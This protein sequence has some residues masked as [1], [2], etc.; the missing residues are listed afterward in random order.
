MRKLIIILFA[1][2]YLFGCH[3]DQERGI[4][5]TSKNTV[6]DTVFKNLHT[7]WAAEQANKTEFVDWLDENG[8]YILAFD[9]IQDSISN[10]PSNEIALKGSDIAFEHGYLEQSLTFLKHYKPKTERDS[11][12]MLFKEY[13]LYL[14]QLH[15]WKENSL[16]TEIEKHLSYIK[17]D[18]QL[19]FQ[20]SSDMGM[21]YHNT[22]RYDTAIKLNTQAYNWAKSSNY[23]HSIIAMCCQRLGN[24]YND[25][26][27]KKLVQG[28]DKF[29]AYKKAA[30]L[31][32][33]CLNELNKITP[34]PKERIANCYFTYAFLVRAGNYKKNDVSLYEKALKMIVPNTLQRDK[35]DPIFCL[36]PL[37]ASIIY[38]HLGECL[39]SDYKNTHRSAYTAKCLKYANECCYYFN[40]L[41]TEPDYQGVFNDILCTYSQR[42]TE[43][44]INYIY[45]CTPTLKVDK[46]KLLTLSNSCKYALLN[47]QHAMA[48]S[49][50]LSLQLSQI[51]MLH[52]LEYMAYSTGNK[53][54]KNIAD[55]A[56]RNI[57]T[58]KVGLLYLPPAVDSN[59]I[60]KIQRICKDQNLAVIDFCES[61]YKLL[62][63]CIDED[64]VI[65]RY[66]P[67][68]NSIFE[69]A[70]QIKQASIANDPRLYD[71]LSNCLYRFLFSNFLDGKKYKKIIIVPSTVARAALLDGLTSSRSDSKQWSDLDYLGNHFV[72]QVVPRIDWIINDKG[73]SPSRFNLFYYPVAFKNTNSLPY[74]KELERF[75]AEEYKASEIKTDL[76][77]QPKVSINGILHIATHTN[78]DSIGSINLLLDKYSINPMK[79]KPIKCKMVVLN[80]CDASNGVRYTNEG[81]ISLARLFIAQGADAVIT[82]NDKVDNHASAE[83]FKRFY[84]YLSNGK[85]TSESLR[86]SKV[87][88]RKI[89][90]EWANPIYWT[91][92]QLWGKD[93]TFYR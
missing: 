34:L 64:R 35:N 21:H 32:E 59:Y 23:D 44:L 77:D 10:H 58:D 12:V 72:I 43:Q 87:D 29:S 28:K 49:P 46:C 37:L 80:T 7:I 81:Q 20:Y 16:I 33:E 82:S 18:S 73:E 68:I 41:L 84:Y 67:I 86:L 55:Y 19:Y 75:L 78:I 45:D 52:S 50:S 47:K 22:G 74:N 89:T 14:S 63:T 3:S 60:K 38:T 54:I 13:R 25:Q 26:V 31:Y 5:V 56:K 91:Q 66:Q 2:L 53:D 6:V 36:N 4:S 79:D 17:S 83:L 85:T 62:I 27:R 57:D 92:Y 24:D 39:N 48:Q 76:L 1:C 51:T 65:T 8:G 70:D 30:A 15:T 61:D 93:L 71:S 90:P 69:K 9:Y 40:Q 88:I 42:N 11:V